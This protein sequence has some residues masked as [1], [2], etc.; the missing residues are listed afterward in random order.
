[1]K[2]EYRIVADNGVYRY[3]I[4]K[5]SKYSTKTNPLWVSIGFSDDLE[6]AEE[7]LKK[8]VAAEAKEP[9]GTVIRTYTEADLIV[10]RLKGKA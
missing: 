10:D 9:T 1:M 3:V 4:K 8:L 6:E 7:K 5:T 2:I